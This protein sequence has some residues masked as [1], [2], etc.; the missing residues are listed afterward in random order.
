VREI[1]LLGRRVD[2]ALAR[3][4][5]ARS[6]RLWV[7]PEGL[8]VTA[9]P[10]LPIR[11]VEAAVRSRAAWALAHLDRLPPAAPPLADG[12]RLPLLGADVR[13][14]ATPGP[15]SRFHHDAP[16]G[17][18]DVEVAGGARLEDVVERWYRGLARAHFA[19]LADERAARLGVGYRSLAVRD[20]RTRW[21]SCSSRGAL[22]F[23]WR[24][25]MAPR[26]VGEYIASHE[27]AHLVRL[28]HSPAFWA[29]VA[30]LHP[31]WPADRDWLD[32]HSA[33]LRR[34]LSDPCVTRASP[35][36]PRVASYWAL[37]E[38]LDVPSG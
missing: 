22:S 34:G 36:A 19:A 6:V 17:R 13:L 11:E 21:A 16:A 33:A 30:R 26:R 8:R 25:M 35:L 2:Y 28:D 29:L 24:L 31:T 15:R 9:P 38:A 32:R 4:P 37:V 12:A 5:R 3:H 14:R 1:E 27:V 18:L 7:G 20:G 10:R 23:G